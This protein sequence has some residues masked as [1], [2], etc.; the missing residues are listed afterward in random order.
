MHNLK[1]LEPLCLGIEPKASNLRELD[2]KSEL[3]GTNIY[4]SNTQSTLFVIARFS[5]A[6]LV[7]FL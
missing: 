7:R 6:K 4:L 2:A 1:I 5:P 3:A